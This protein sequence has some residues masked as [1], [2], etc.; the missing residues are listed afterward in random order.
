[1]ALASRNYKSGRTFEYRT[2][3]FL[4]KIGYYVIRSY[5]SKG[6]FDLVAVPP[7][8]RGLGSQTLLI[9]CKKNGYVKPQERDRLKEN[10]KWLGLPLIAW[11]ERK[12]LF[13]TL[14]GDRIE[15]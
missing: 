2:Q 5:G 1:M 10:D 15:L 4:R 6:L 13:R 11:S 14:G 9:Q 7:T 12:L 3:N 8:T